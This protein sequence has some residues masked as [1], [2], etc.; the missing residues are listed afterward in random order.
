LKP[1][2]GRVPRTGGFPA[3]LLDYETVGP[4]ARSV[5]DVNLIME[6]IGPSAPCDP[7]STPFREKPFCSEA[8]ETCRI[9]FVPQFGDAPVDPE[10]AEAVTAAANRL[11]EMG[12]RVDTGP[13]PFDISLVDKAWPV[14]SQGGLA[15]LSRL[16]SRFPREASPL[17]RDMASQGDSLSAADYVDALT[18]IKRVDSQL[19][20][21]FE[22]YDLILTPSAAALPWKADEAFPSE[23]A[24]RA[25]GPRG[26]AVFT[27]FVNLAGAAG[28][29]LPCGQSQSGLPIGLQLVVRAGRD[30]LLTA[31]ASQCEAANLCTVT[32]PNGIPALNEA[33]RGLPA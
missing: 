15:W 27:A 11:R 6:I 26:H 17:M 14:I 18:S 29:S 1:S 4:I 30:G 3:I 10:I 12:H 22:T 13:A 32:L 24:G 25:V 20:I 33:L 19:S 9:L 16:C 8:A 2:R 7:A 21:A 28:I 23:I 31:I 5:A